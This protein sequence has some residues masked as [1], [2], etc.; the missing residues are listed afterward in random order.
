[1]TSIYYHHETRDALRRR[2]SE[3]CIAVVPLAATEQHGPHLP[4]YTDS[5][6]CEHIAVRACEQASASIDLLL[7]PTLTIGC[8]AHHLPFG[9]TLSFSSSTYLSMLSDIGDSLVAGGFRR[10]AFLNGHGGNEPIM[11]QTAQDL[12]VRHDIWT[13]SASYWSLSRSSLGALNAGETGMVPGHAGGFEAS[14]IAAL[15]PELMKWDRMQPDHPQRQWINAG[16]P[17]AFVGKHGLLTGVDG[18]TD[19]PAAAD[20]AKGKAYLQA[21]VDATAAWLI[22]LN[23]WMRSGEERA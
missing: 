6:I 20:A 15:A 22:Q 19:T 16:P 21:I 2:A 11:Q 5:L 13:A 10:I 3:G 18:Y 1:M 9:G 23:D 7:T 4:V 17:G 14:L 8:S 12:A